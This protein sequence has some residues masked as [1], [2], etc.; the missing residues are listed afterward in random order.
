ML[1]LQVE[2]NLAIHVKKTGTGIFVF[3]KQG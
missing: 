1:K 2:A 3:I